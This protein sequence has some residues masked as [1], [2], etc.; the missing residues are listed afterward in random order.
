MKNTQRH[1]PAT[2]RYPPKR[3]PAAVAT[4]PTP[5]QAPMA[6][7]RSCRRKDAWRM[8]RLAGARRAP[9]TPWSTRAAIS[10]PAF[11]ANP[12]QTEATSNQTTPMKNMRLRPR[13]SPSE[14]PRRRKAARVSE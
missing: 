11:G 5:D 3:G 14:P 2:I 13:R 9:P 6:R 12:Q 7:E 8:A 10:T 1:D 4:P